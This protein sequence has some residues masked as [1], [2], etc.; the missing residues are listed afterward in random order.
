LALLDPHNLGA[1]SF[2]LFESLDPLRRIDV[3]VHV[4]L[5]DLQRNLDLYTSDYQTQFNDFAPG[6]RDHIR[7]AGM[8]QVALR[9]AILEY[10]TEKLV[11]LGL[12]R[13]EHLQLIR[14]TN[15]QRLYWLMLLARHELAHEF[16]EK[17][18]SIAREPEF[19]F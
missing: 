2:D 12:P 13:A 17:I 4:S 14:G 9:A 16:W 18:T 6:W 15:N 19:D 3:I 5:G 1:L 7:T 8:N 10:W 11:R